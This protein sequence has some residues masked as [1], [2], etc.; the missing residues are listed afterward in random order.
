MNFR[1]KLFSNLSR[2]RGNRNA[3]HRT[4]TETALHSVIIIDL[5]ALILL[6][7]STTI[8]R[9]NSTRGRG[10]NVIH[11]LALFLCNL[12]TAS[13]DMKVTV[14]LHTSFEKIAAIGCVLVMPLRETKYHSLI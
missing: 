3:R 10:V 9:V 8:Q 4:C 14:E 6:Q 7:I 2:G 12:T 5:L 11:V 13:F 1:K